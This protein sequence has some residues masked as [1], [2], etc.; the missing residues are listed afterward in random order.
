MATT[1][2]GPAA[3]RRTELAGSQRGR[4][5]R[6]GHRAQH[7]RRSNSSR[8]APPGL[9]AKLHTRASSIRK[10]HPRPPRRSSRDRGG[11]RPQGDCICSARVWEFRTAMAKQTHLSLPGGHAGFDAWRD[12]LRS[13]DGS[14]NASRGY[15]RMTVGV[16]AGV[17]SV[18][19]RVTFPDPGRTV[20]RPLAA[21]T[22]PPIRRQEPAHALDKGTLDG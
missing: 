14:D 12:R 8:S 19:R 11:A 18:D 5:G 9:D 3:H 13:H 7:S 22:L 6:A 17:T 15:R 4:G 10:R 2:D 1:P 20:G 21:T 16:D